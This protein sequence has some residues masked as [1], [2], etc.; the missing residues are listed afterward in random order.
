MTF[1]IE[2]RDDPSDRA[3]GIPTLAGY[4]HLSAD[5]RLCHIALC[6]QAILGR[7]GAQ[8]LLPSRAHTAYETPSSLLRPSSL[9]TRNPHAH[10]FLI[11]LQPICRLHF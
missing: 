11:Q 3:L 5:L 9:V 10:T 6:Y 7:E 2:S 4:D 8:L 1:F